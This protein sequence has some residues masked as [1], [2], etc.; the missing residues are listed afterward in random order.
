[1]LTPAIGDPDAQA[2]AILAHLGLA[3]DA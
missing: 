1:V 2:S 3:A